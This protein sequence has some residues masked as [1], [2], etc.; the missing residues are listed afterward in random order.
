MV[1]AV[2]TGSSDGPKDPHRVPWADTRDLPATTVSLL[3][4]ELG[5]E[6]V[7]DTFPAAALADGDDIDLLALGEDIADL[8]LLL[9]QALRDF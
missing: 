5:A 7:D 6:P 3:L 4:Q 9:E 8:D 2:V 1:E